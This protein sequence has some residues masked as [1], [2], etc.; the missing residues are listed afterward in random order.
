MFVL[1][2]EDVFPV[3]DLG[4]RKGMATLYGYEVEDRAAM[5]DHAARWRPYRTYASRYLWR[6]HD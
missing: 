1:A 4:I 5:V 2:R 3:G 6:V